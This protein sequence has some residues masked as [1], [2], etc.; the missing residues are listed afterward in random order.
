L[1]RQQLRRPSMLSVNYFDYSFPFIPQVECLL[2]DYSSHSCH[3]VECLLL[4]VIGWP[5]LPPR[6]GDASARWCEM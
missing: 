6:P 3:K 2:L 5:P 1:I 4:R